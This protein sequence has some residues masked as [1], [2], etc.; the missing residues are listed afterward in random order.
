[1]VEIIQS[2]KTNF[3]TFKDIYEDSFQVVLNI[4]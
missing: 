3:N 2:F 4:F 1:M